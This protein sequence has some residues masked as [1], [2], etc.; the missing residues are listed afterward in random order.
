ME[1]FN[2]IHMNIFNHLFN[3]KIKIMDKIAIL[4]SLHAFY[5]GFNTP[6]DKARVEEFKAAI[7]A[8]SLKLV[9][10]AWKEPKAAETAKPAEAAKEGPAA[11]AGSLVDKNTPGAKAQEDLKAKVAAE[12]AKAKENAAAAQV[13]ELEAEAA[14]ETT[15]DEDDEKVYDILPFYPCQIKT[16]NGKMF[17]VPKPPKGFTICED[18]ETQTKLNGA[19]PTVDEFDMVM[20]EAWDLACK[21]ASAKDLNA[22]LKKNLEG[23]YA[24][25][26]KSEADYYGKLSNP[27]CSAIAMIKKAFGKHPKDVNVL[28]TRPDGYVSGKPGV[29]IILTPKT[30]MTVLEKP[31]EV[32]KPAVA[33]KPEMKT[34]Q[35]AKPAA[36]KIPTV[37]IP[38]TETPKPNEPVDE[39]AQETN[40][41]ETAGNEEVAETAAEEVVGED[42]AN[43]P[44]VNAFAK[45]NSIENSVA[46]KFIEGEK[47]AAAAKTDDEKKTIK[48]NKREES[49]SLIQ[50]W[51]D[52]KDW[53]ENTEDG[54]WNP[55]LIAYHNGLLREIQSNRANWPKA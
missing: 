42:D 16:E 5:G 24:K 3:P 25:E 14:A 1:Y 54:K 43:A 31:A 28:I 9:P 55:K 29:P 47:L 35:E 49:R 15:E 10:S 8:E 20:D 37:V 27:I 19:Y 2:S 21:G 45:F 51:F 48:N 23:W 50:S 18:E 17:D 34:I 32:A 39:E 30:D 52:G 40:T 4:I 38:K 46:E 36:A 33:A 44:A 7:D 26:L 13:A 22:M 12:A 53:V 6:K 41:E 11:K